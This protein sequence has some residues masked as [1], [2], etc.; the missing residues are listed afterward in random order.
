MLF[1]VP[2]RISHPILKVIEDMGGRFIAFRFSA[3]VVRYP[4]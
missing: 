1:E 4:I 2:E 3:K